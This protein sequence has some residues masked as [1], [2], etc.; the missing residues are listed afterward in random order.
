MILKK[1]EFKKCWRLFV[2][3]NLQNIKMYKY[4]LSTKQI[5]THENERFKIFVDKSYFIV[6]C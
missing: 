4:F 5:G 2:N 6:H 3:I 1:E